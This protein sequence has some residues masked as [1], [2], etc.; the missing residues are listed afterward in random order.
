MDFQDNTDVATEATI[1]PLRPE[2]ALEILN[3]SLAVDAI[4][5]DNPGAV[6]TM[7][8]Q[9][10]PASKMRVRATTSRSRLLNAMLVK[11]ARGKIALDMSGM[12]RRRSFAKRSTEA[13]N[14]MEASNADRRAVATY[15]AGHFSGQ[16]LIAALGLDDDGK[17]WEE[18]FTL[19]LRNSSIFLDLLV[20]GSELGPLVRL[21]DADRLRLR[22]R[23]VA[24]VALGL[25]QKRNQKSVRS[26]YQAALH[27]LAS[28]WREQFRGRT[29]LDSHRKGAGLGDWWAKRHPALNEHAAGLRLIGSNKI[30]MRIL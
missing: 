8:Q 6:A 28:D 2:Y 11:M 26:R 22:T 14:L 17:S 23:I 30:L 9:I 25:I 1:V 24:S 16:A 18:C 21:S 3:T 7:T 27:L 20:V 19:L 12:S 10:K 5:R 4:L 13:L 29:W 15:L